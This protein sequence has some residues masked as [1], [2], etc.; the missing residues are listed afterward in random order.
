[1]PKINPKALA[2]RFQA[3]TASGKTYSEFMEAAS[4]AFLGQAMPDIKGLTGDHAEVVKIG[5]SSRSRWLEYKGQDR[6][7]IDLELIIHLFPTSASDVT[8]IC[9]GRSAERGRLDES[10]R[11]K[12]GQLTPQT[13]VNLFLEQFGR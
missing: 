5:G 12:W 7:D 4:A 9:S 1:M 8:V 13:I 11:M 2:E 10:R 6:S 3:K